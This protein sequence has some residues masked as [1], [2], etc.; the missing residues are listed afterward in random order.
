MSRQERIVKAES[1]KEFC[2]QTLEK[3]NVPQKEAEITSDVLVSADLRG[4]ESH[5]V[6]RLPR[7]AKRLMNGW[8]R[9]EAKLT[10]KKET[11]TSLLIEGENS[12]GQVVA[13]KSME[14]CIEKAKKSHFGFASRNE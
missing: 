1:L 14:R 10:V 11:L 3:L 8:T 12:L 7:Y 4:I 13:Y 2:T 9:P 6:S 5:G